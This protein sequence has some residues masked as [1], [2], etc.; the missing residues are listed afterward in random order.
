MAGRNYLPPHAL[1]PRD[2]SLKRHP[3]P[4]HPALIDDPRLHHRLPGPPP[5]PAFL[6]AHHALEDD[7]ITRR[8]EFQALLLER[9]R[10]D[11]I[12]V[13]LEQEIAAAHQ[14]LRD[15]KAVG[16]DIKS[17]KDAQVR[18]VYERTLKKQTEVDLIDVLDAELAQV[19]DN[20]QKLKA[21]NEERTAK[22][23][24]IQDDIA[25]AHP[26]LQQLPAIKAEVEAEHQEIEKGRAAVEH[27][28]K[29]QVINDEY[30]Q[31]MEKN[32][33]SKAREIEKLRAEL[34]HA[35]K[36]ARAAAAA[37]AATP[38]PGYVGYGGI[39]YHDTY[40]MHQKKYDPRV[41]ERWMVEA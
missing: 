33:F 14:K 7:I 28:K 9:Q 22:L 2:G 10:L 24:A 6:R 4:P 17:E 26:E 20:I 15:L 16:V 38:S 30:G 39:S 32:V 11:A 3:R 23:K 25:K 18:D 12:H 31:T 21:E 8:R 36:R 27:E 34:A 5:P 29:V 1:N 40:N 13:A 35:E 41:K 19:K 37:A